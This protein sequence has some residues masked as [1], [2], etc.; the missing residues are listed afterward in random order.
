MIAVEVLVIELFFRLFISEQAWIGVESAEALVL[1]ED[2][3]A[4]W[5]VKGDLPVGAVTVVPNL[6]YL[7]QII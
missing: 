1:K 4:V 7:D 2:G 6:R 5:Q 3:G